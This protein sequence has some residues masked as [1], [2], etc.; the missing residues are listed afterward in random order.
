MTSPKMVLNCIVRDII[1]KLN[2]DHKEYI[3]Q[4]AICYKLQDIGYKIERE[5]VRDDMHDWRFNPTWF[6]LSTN[7]TVGGDFAT[8]LQRLKYCECL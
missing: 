1:E 6:N 2:Y 4:K 8:S 7:T 3:Y 5:V